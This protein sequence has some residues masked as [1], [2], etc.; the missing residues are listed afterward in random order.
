MA[1]KALAAAFFLLGLRLTEGAVLVTAKDRSIA[2]K[3]NTKATSLCKDLDYDVPDDAKESLK[4]A[5]G[6]NFA[7]DSMRGAK[8]MDDFQTRL[9]DS[10]DVG[11]VLGSAGPMVAFFLFLVA[12][13]L[14][15][16]TACP[17]CKCCRIRERH[18][19]PHR[20]FKMVAAVVIGAI[21]VGIVIAA[22][23]SRNGF[24]LA[25]SGFK[26]S[27]CTGAKLLNKTLS[28]NA[29]PHF[30]GMIPSLGLL[31]ELVAS[32][33]TGSQFMQDL[34]VQ[35]TST[36]PIEE[37]V[38]L[39]SGTLTLL[40]DM[41]ASP[42]NVKPKTAAGVDLLHQCEICP[43]LE[44]VLTPAINDLNAGMGT[45]LKNA[46]GEV[47][48]QLSGQ[49]LIDL[50]SSVDKAT[51]P[52]GEMKKLFVES[53]GWMVDSNTMP[54][55]ADML[56]T[57]GL[58]ACLAVIALV[59]LVASCAFTTMGLWTFKEMRT[60][61]EKTEYTKRVHRCACVSWCCGCGT[62]LVAF[63]LGGFMTLLSVPLSSVCLIMDDV[64]GQML[65]DIAGPLK[66][67][68][69]GDM[70]TMSK[71]MIDQCFRNPDKTANPLLLDII[72][73]R[74][75][76]DN[77]K[78]LLRKTIVN[79]TKDMIDSQF[80]EITKSMSMGDMNLAGSPNIVKLRTKLATTR[81]DA[82]TLIPVTYDFANSAYAKMS[83]D[84]KSPA[85][86]GLPG[87]WLS[88]GACDDFLVPADNG[89]QSGKT[90]KGVST[91]S[92]YLALT[93]GTVPNPS[94]SAPTCWRKV[95]CKHNAGTNPG[96]RQACDAA[97]DFMQLKQDLRS[98]NTF[99]CRLFK[100][101]NGNKCDVKDM[102]KLPSG[103]YSN[104]C[105]KADGSLEV[106]EYPCTL[107][108]FTTLVQQFTDR[109]DKVFTRLDASTAATLTGINV[110]MKGLVNTN[111][112]KKI[113]TFGDGV[114]CGFLGDAYQEF[115]RSVCY[116]GV[117]GFTKVS[118][119]YVACGVLTLV[120][121]IIMYI[122]WRIAVDNYNH[123]TDGTAA[124]AGANNQPAAEAP[125]EEPAV[126]E[127]EINPGNAEQ[128]R[129]V[130]LE[131]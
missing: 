36:K 46:R 22:G 82:M 13:M 89:A 73:T 34:K 64:S 31:D 11:F 78:V 116:S 98:A 117:V 59:G 50:R 16:W 106:L 44:E 100:D 84:P 81:V 107:D 114:T 56:D 47:E 118:Y 32:L 28:G 86:D 112:N 129:Q 99:K 27:T 18:H 103:K 105:M 122:V 69:T 65:D 3:A 115:I 17:R 40:K 104:D 128:E 125:K 15:C 102:V 51:A 80:S 75:V 10:I 53:F 76:T 60:I 23:V 97:N 21:I 35:L 94:I 7:L 111:V 88:G 120:L 90:I 14:C 101:S 126:V 93:F 30:L 42:A 62:L 43:K 74:N 6:D 130:V 110:D 37:A 121:V 70:G 124:A 108:E 67:N 48:K 45:K 58:V 1:L 26:A 57:Y 52:L 5:S 4:S 19:K 9:T 49:A 113:E 109:I 29:E 39:T 66:L 131:L 20:I 72:F 63:L 12:F 83:L 41:M 2:A 8:D 54:D 119:S 25:S 95:T 33:D 79:D 71:D 85:A 68:M 61:G 55:F 92:K 123:N 38:A 127:Q 24:N 96:E 91:F 77:K 87:F